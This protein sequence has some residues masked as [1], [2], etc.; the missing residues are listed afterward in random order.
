MADRFLEDFAIGQR[1]VSPGVTVSESMILDFA[2][3][4]D[5][6]PFHLDAEAAKETF[7]GG[8]I[9]SGFQTLALGFRMLLQ[10]DLFGAS[11][12]GS[13]GIDELRWPR[14]VRP[15]DTIHGELEVAETTPSRSK[16]DRGI[17]KTAVRIVNQRGEDV[18]TFK[19]MHLLRRRPRA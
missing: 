10:L 3:R 18:M 15:G 5:P 11:S 12:M 1:F 17:L 4:Y 13:P 7:F 14:P 16:P 9:A 6:Q 19:G 8:L 2:L